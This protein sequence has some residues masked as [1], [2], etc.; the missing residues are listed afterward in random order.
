[1]HG[2]AENVGNS[3]VVPRSPMGV[4]LVGVG[5]ITGTIGEKQIQ[6]K[7]ISAPTVVLLAIS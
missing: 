5:V 3:L 6:A 4:N 1:M 2:N 7:V